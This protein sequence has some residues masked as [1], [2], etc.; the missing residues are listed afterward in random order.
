[1]GQDASGE[2]AWLRRK[3]CSQCWPEQDFKK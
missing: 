3:Q 1:L 2:S